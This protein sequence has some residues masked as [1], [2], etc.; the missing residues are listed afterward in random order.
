ML[1]IA[2]WEA[3]S[4]KQR[5]D[6]TL[7]EFKL[8]VRNYSVKHI[9]Q[10]PQTLDEAFAIAKSTATL[11][12]GLGA[13]RKTR[14]IE[15]EDGEHWLRGMQLPDE[16]RSRL[17]RLETANQEQSK[18]IQK[19]QSTIESF[20]SRQPATTPNRGCFRCGDLNHFEKIVLDLHLLGAWIQGHLHLDQAIILQIWG[21][22]SNLITH[23]QI[24]T[25]KIKHNTLTRVD[26][27]TLHLGIIYHQQETSSAELGHHNHLK[28]WGTD[29]PHLRI[30]QYA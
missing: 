13:D 24:N 26:T 18:Q 20:I 14:R 17:R 2:R 9:Q 6:E 4:A 30:H 12:N 16:D 19:L 29:P 25:P 8:R 11:R 10:D 15:V 22:T 21:D 7:Y 5:E 1:F 3:S 27:G 28:G 23:I